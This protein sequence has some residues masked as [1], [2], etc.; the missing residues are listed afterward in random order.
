VFDLDR[1]G[2][3]A[4]A[5]AQLGEDLHRFW[6]RYRP[7]LRTRTRD[8]SAYALTFWR[9]QLTMEDQRNFANID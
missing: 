7:S 4:R 5:V 9:G 1:W 3:P 8:T 6:Q 2:L